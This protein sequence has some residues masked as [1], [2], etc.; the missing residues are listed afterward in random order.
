MSLSS[1]SFLALSSKSFLMASLE[2]ATFGSVPGRKYSVLVGQPSQAS[3]PVMVQMVAWIRPVGA[4]NPGDGVV[5][6]S[7][8][9]TRL[10]MGEAP[11]TPEA[12]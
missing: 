12:T 6:R 4:A 9:I 10:Q 2:Q 3:W 5:L 7:P 8:R 1:W 11:V